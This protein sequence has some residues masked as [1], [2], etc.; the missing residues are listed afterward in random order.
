MISPFRTMMA[1]PRE[2]KDLALALLNRLTRIP[3]GSGPPWVPHP[4][5]QCSSPPSYVRPFLMSVSPPEPLE[6]LI[7]NTHHLTL[8]Y[9][10]IPAPVAIFQ[11]P[12]PYLLSP[13]FA[14][15]TLPSK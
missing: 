6:S 13:A 8:F 4:D 14:T 1:L 12:T 2:S 11:A 9:A 3:Q 15:Y 7:L 5:S 10:P